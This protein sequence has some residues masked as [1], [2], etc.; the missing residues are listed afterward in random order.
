MNTIQR[1]RERQG[2]M[3]LIWKDAVKNCPTRQHTIINYMSDNGETVL[4]EHAVLRRGFKVTF[5]NRMQVYEL[6]ST[7]G[8]DFYKYATDAQIDK[9]LK[10]GFVRACDEY[11]IK[12]HERKIERYNKNIDLSN[13]ERNDS[14]ITHWRNRRME[15][16]NDKSTIE[17]G[18][19]HWP[20]TPLK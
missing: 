3:E 7:H 14:M 12:R 2:D 20:R 17:E 5:N 15:L 4:I 8:G 16:I 10:V 19:A 6:L 13:A 11:Q 9:F 1:L 18:L